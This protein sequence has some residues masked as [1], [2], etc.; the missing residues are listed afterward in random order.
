MNFKSYI[1]IIITTVLIGCYFLLP[2]PYK[3]IGIPGLM[4]LGATFAKAYR[5]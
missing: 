3:L 5:K 1:L 4:L 2:F